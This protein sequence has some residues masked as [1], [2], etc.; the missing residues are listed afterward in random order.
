MRDF[1]VLMGFLAMILPVFRM[2][3]IGVLIWCWTAMVV[4]MAYTYGFAMSVPFNKI[5]ALITLTAW[6][7]S[8]EPKKFPKNLALIL[9]AVF[10]VMA[11]ISAYA[12]IAPNSETTMT[13]W[14]KFYKVIIFVF[15]VVGL[16]TTKERIDALLYAIYLSLGFHGVVEGAKFIASLGGHHVF[17]PEGS[18]LGDNNHFALAMVAMLPIVLYLYKQASHRLV[19]LALLGSSLL[20]MASVMGT[21]SR[22][23]LVGILAVG[24]YTFFRSKQK[25]KFLL[26]VLPIVAAAIAFAPERWTNRMDTISEAKGDE[27]FMLRVI[28][29][30]QS[31]LIALSNPVFGGGFHAVQDRTVWNAMAINF[32]RLSFVESPL[33]DSMARAAHSIYFQVLGDQGFVGLLIFLG[34]LATSWRN[35]SVIARGAAGRPE[36]RWALE[37]STSLKYCMIAYIVSGASLSMAYFE[38]IYMIFALLVVLRNIVGEP[39]VRG[40]FSNAIGSMSAAR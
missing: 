33:P 16:V 20:T 19:K 22:G 9:I 17:G 13:E 11:T 24:G 39:V 8:K 34:I 32:D 2:P 14:G 23:G 40:R 1:A 26:A 31:T 25:A 6:L 38:Y 28:A 37:L 21:F 4:P 15:V 12:G 29:W 30:K 27:S 18:I 5:V 35:A 3:H 10:G 7:A 36:L